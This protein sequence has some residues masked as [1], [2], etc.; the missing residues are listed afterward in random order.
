MGFQ[1]INIRQV[2]WEELKTSAWGLG[3]Q[4]LPRD[5]AK[6]N[7]WKTMFDPYIV[8]SSW[9]GPVWGCISSNTVITFYIWTDSLVPDN[10]GI[11]YSNILR[12]H[13][14]KF[15]TKRHIQTV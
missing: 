13:S 14:P 8:V 2:P 9:N 15:L 4:H 6:V 11:R 1:C 3:F 7:A 5:L 10:V 12:F